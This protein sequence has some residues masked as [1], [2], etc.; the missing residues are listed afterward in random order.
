[1]AAPIMGVGWDGRSPLVV[2]QNVGLHPLNFHTNGAAALD[3][4]S[5]SR[6]AKAVL[7]QV[8]AGACRQSNQQ[9]NLRKELEVVILAGR[10]RLHVILIMSVQ[11]YKHTIA[12]MTISELL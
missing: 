12:C 5:I 4:V 2:L 10:A 8:A 7:G 9:V 6:L 11:P 1:M 3:R